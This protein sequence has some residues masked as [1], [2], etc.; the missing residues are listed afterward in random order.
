MSNR[1][2]LGIIACVAALL[3][4]GLL[5]GHT[6][7]GADMAFGRAPSAGGAGRDQKPEVKI[8]S[9]PKTPV[10]PAGQRKKLVFK[11]ELSI[12]QKDRSSTVK[13]I[14]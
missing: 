5:S 14:F 11:E 12:G 2:F 7:L 8:I 1:H 10:P 13:G 9:N 3:A 4:A 6:P